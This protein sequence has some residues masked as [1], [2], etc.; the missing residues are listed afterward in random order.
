LAQGAKLVQMWHGIPLKEIEL[1][2]YARHLA[3]IPKW[4]R[5]FE[6]LQTDHVTLPQYCLARIHSPFMTVHAFVP[7][8]HYVKVIE[9]GYPRNFFILSQVEFEDAS[10]II[11]EFL[12]D[13]P[14]TEES[15]V[16][17]Q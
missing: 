17:L 14:K 8:F 1:P 3:R 12:L 13:G 16:G 7:S 6:S 2:G 10:I 9:P 15:L 4:R 11:Q 5:P